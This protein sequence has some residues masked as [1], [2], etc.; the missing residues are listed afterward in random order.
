[1]QNSQ[2][3]SKFNSLSINEMKATQGGW[4]LFGTETT[5]GDPRSIVGNQSQ[6]TVTSTTYFLGFVTDSTSKT[7]DDGMDNY[8]AN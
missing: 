6:Q 7:Y 5:K 8:P 2:I 4:R 1:M 3:N